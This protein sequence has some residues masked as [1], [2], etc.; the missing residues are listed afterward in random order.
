MSNSLEIDNI[1]AS[2]AMEGIVLDQDT[3]ADL[4]KIERGELNAD[5]A[6]AAV[7]ARIRAHQPAG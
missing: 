2:A 4:D 5:D 3:I 1:I 6:V 7:I